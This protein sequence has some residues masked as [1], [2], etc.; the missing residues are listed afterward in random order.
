MKRRMT[1]TIYSIETAAGTIQLQASADSFD[2]Q[3][4]KRH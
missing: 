3:A 1:L 4:K 2:S